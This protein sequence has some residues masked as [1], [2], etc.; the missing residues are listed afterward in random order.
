MDMYRL[1]LAPEAFALALTRSKPVAG[2]MASLRPDGKWD[3]AVT[4]ATADQLKQQAAPGENLSDTVMRI[5]GAV[6]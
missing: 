4:A 5:L 3:V 6:Q 1:T 2:R